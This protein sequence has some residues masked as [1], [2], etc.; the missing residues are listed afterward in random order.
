MAIQIEAQISKEELP[1]AAKCTSKAI[2]SVS[3]IHAAMR[4]Q[5]N[6]DQSRLQYTATLAHMSPERR[7]GLG[8]LLAAM[9]WGGGPNTGIDAKSNDTSPEDEASN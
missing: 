6:L 2:Q 9:A 8:E 5:A 1:W 3:K 4:R 7:V